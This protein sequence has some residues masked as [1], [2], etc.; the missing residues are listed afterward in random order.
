MATDSPADFGSAFSKSGDWSFK[1]EGVLDNIRINCLYLSSRYKIRYFS[2][3]SSIKWYRLPIIILSGANSI[4]AVGLQPYIE[5]GIISLTNSL[6]A[7]LCGIIGSI[8]LFLKINARMESDLISQRDFYLLSIEIF[9]TLSLDRNNRYVPAKEY[10]EKIY[11]DYCKLIESSNPL[12]SSITDKL[13][14][15]DFTKEDQRMPFN[16]NVEQVIADDD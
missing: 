10:M 12:E 14:P 7:L 13:L 11:N 1:I 3:S 2:L 6:I 9:K 16:I 4:I 15:V 8:E 5:Q